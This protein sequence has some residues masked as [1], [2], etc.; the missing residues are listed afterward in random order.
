MEPITVSRLRFDVFLSFRGQDT[1]QNTTRRLYETLNNK[2]NV[3]VFCGNDG[4]KRGDEISTS[5]EAAMED[6]ATSVIV[7][8]RNYANS[9][10]GLDELAM[11]CDLR[12]SLNRPII[13]IFYMVDPR[14]FRTQNGTFEVD[15]EEHSKSFS[16]EKIQ[17]WRRAMN[18]VGNISGF[19][20]RYDYNMAI[21]L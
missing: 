7:L 6:S 11:L 17:K 10:W 14:H 2:E 19:V 16:E 12:A 9:H 18:L 3:R 1:G 20:Y 15:F 4:M 13:P 8:S 5:L 21:S